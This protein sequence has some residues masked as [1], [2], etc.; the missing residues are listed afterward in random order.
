MPITRATVAGIDVTFAT[1]REP[2]QPYAEG[3][4]LRNGPHRKTHGWINMTKSNVENREVRIEDLD[5]VAGGM[6]FYGMG[7]S[8][9]QDYAID[10]IVKG[11]ESVPVIGGALGAI[12]T[13]LGRAFCGGL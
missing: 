8:V 6:P 4:E 1:V 13:F 2:R 10:G 5:D 3:R 11:L 7:C 9:N 12:G